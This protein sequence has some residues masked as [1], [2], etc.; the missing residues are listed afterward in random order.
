MKT[1]PGS[2]VDLLRMPPGYTVL[3]DM[4]HWTRHELDSYKNHILAGQRHQIHESQYFQWREITLTGGRPPRITTFLEKEPWPGS[5]L[6][7][8]SLER[9]YGQRVLMETSADP[10]AT[11]QTMS[12][13]LPLARTSHVYAAYSVELLNY[14]TGTHAQEPAMLELLMI[15]GRMEKLGPL[16]VGVNGWDLRYM[17]D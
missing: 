16:H 2:V 4:K 11:V 7:Y 3:R 6:Q 15:V 1:Y 14:L 8:T 10:A 5:S 9:L 13:G 12:S 17:A